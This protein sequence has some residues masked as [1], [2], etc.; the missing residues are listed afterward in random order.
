MRQRITQW[1][2]R[3]ITKTG[4]LASLLVFV[5]L[6]FTFDTI[7]VIHN[8]LN[9]RSQQRAV[10]ANRATNVSTWCHAIDGLQGQLLTYVSNISA[11]ATKRHPGTH[12]SPTLGLTLKHLDCQTL[13]KNTA[14][15]AEA[16][17]RGR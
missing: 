14:T 3:P 13:E 11:E 4:L 6:L 12:Y 7:L 8:T 9:V 2:A 5:V 16:G 10:A 15:S 1:L 17:R